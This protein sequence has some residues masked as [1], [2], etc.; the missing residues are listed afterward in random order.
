M[1]ASDLEIR[2]LRADEQT[3]ATKILVE[4][5][6]D[7]YR[8]SAPIDIAATFAEYPYAPIS[9]IALYD[10]HYCGFVQTVST[11]IHKNMYSILWLAVT[12]EYRRRGFAAR[13]L[14]KA[15]EYVATN[16]FKGADGSFILVS[17]YKKEY[18]ER[19]GYANGIKTFDGYPIMIKHFRS[20]SKLYGS[21]AV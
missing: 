1:I 19:M 7:K 11:Y 8:D 9:F 14:A 20:P 18:Y 4:C 21:P 13:L 16:L 12:P 5:F 10:G 3:I 2:R 17:E 6:G 15:E